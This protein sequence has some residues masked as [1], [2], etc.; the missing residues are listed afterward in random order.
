MSLHTHLMAPSNV[1]VSPRLPYAKADRACCCCYLSPASTI[2]GLYDPDLHAAR[3]FDTL[4]SVVCMGAEGKRQREI[5]SH[6]H[7]QPPG[8]SSDSLTEGFVLPWETTSPSL[9]GLYDRTRLRACGKRERERCEERKR[10]RQASSGSAGYLCS[11]ILSTCCLGSIHNL[12][13]RLPVR[14][15]LPQLSK[16]MC[17]LFR[18][19]GE[20]GWKLA[21]L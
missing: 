9:L 8:V 16:G 2:T 15:I 12:A 14:D 19:W 5:K 6:A 20:V 21:L 11:S 1:E 13:E 7:H 17:C 3:V 10:E 4:D 18:E